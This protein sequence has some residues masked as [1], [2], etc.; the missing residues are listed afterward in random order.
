MQRM[1]ATLNLNNKI[2]KRILIGIDDQKY[3]DET[4]EIK[5]SF[6]GNDFSTCQLTKIL[7]LGRNNVYDLKCFVPVNGQT[8]YLNVQINACLTLNQ[9]IN[10]HIHKY[11]N[12]VNDICPNHLLIPTKNEISYGTY[13]GDPSV[14]SLFISD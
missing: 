11:S 5:L 9:S 1:A 3:S 2:I 13:L 4:L 7:N 14:V 12:P 8:I 6:D 10:S